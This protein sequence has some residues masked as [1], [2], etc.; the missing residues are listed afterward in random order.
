MAWWPAARPPA[1]LPAGDLPLVGRA[2]EAR[3]S[4]GEMPLRTDNWRNYIPPYHGATSR[5]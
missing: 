5:E 4:Y 2:A 1:R 3:R